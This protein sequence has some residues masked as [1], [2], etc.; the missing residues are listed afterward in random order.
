[1]ALKDINKPEYI[2]K[3]INEYDR[4]GRELFL[5]TY[6]YG[7]SKQYLLHHKGHLY[8]SK[9]IV[10]VAH[11]YARPDIGPISSGIHFGGMQHAVKLLQK[12]GFEIN[13]GSEISAKKS[14]EII[15]AMEGKAF[16]SETKFRY[17][18]RNLIAQKKSSSDYRCEVCKILFKEVYGR[19][20]KKFIIAHHNRPM[21]KGPR[22]T[23]LKDI[24][25]VCPNCHAMLHKGPPF[26][27][28]E[29]KNV[30]K[31]KIKHAKP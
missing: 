12:L 20:G 1:M 15:E 14:I 5:K 6:K 13:T 11:K 2:L 19:I 17:R 4:L 28:E 26:T 25:L 8:D 9:A 21:A 29:L 16:I 24:D 30:L 3:A 23:R 22:T 10:G 7:P 31:V 27:I 18:N